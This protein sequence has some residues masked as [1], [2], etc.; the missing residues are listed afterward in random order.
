MEVIICVEHT[1]LLSPWNGSVLLFLQLIEGLQL[2][3]RLL[4]LVDTMSTVLLHRNVPTIL[5]ICMIYDLDVSLK[6]AGCSDNDYKINPF[7]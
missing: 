6:S 7:T 2:S 5:T 4:H 1:Y 3:G